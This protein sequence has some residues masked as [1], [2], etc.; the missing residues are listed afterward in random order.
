MHCKTV[1]CPHPDVCHKHGVVCQAC[2]EQV[3]T[4]HMKAHNDEFH[5]DD[6]EDEEEEE[7]EDEDDDDDGV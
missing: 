3:C 5:P 7:E 2:E 6:D 1:N 4:I